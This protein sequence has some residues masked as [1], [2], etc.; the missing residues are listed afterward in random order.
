[1]AKFMFV[2]RNGKNEQEPSPEEMQQAMKVWMDWIDN[3]TQAG[4][5]LDGGDALKPDGKLVNPDNTVTDG[6]FAES[7]ELVSGYSM[8]QADSYDAAVELAKGSPMISVHRGYV[9]V[10]E[11]AEVGKDQ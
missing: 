6:P 4:W 3:G 11:L 9:E 2:Y 7:K 5:L 8:V 1:M 10:R